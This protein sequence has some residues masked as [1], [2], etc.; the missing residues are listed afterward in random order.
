M[1]AIVHALDATANHVV[2]PVDTSG[3]LAPTTSLRIRDSWP[4]AP[5]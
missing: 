1:G 2:L 4:R 5:S 3:T